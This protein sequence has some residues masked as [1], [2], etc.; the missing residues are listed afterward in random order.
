MCIRF[1]SLD[2]DPKQHSLHN[3]CKSEP[4]TDVLENT[5]LLHGSSLMCVISVIA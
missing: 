2:D 4:T 3:V 1:G 5:E